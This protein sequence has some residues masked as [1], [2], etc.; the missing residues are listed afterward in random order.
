M[1][2]LCVRPNF[3]Q[4]FK[5]KSYLCNIKNNIMKKFFLLFISAFMLAPASAQD[6]ITESSDT[7]Y[8]FWPHSNPLFLQDS[9]LIGNHGSFGSMIW[10]NLATPGTLVY[11][12]S[13]RGELPLDSTIKVSLAWRDQDSQYHYYD[14]VYLDSS[15]VYRQLRFRAKLHV[16]S[17]HLFDF[18][19][20]CNEVY[21][22]RPW[23]V[24]DTFYVVIRYQEIISLPY[25]LL[26]VSTD[27]DSIW[28]QR[29]AY[30]ADDMIFPVF[31]PYPPTT[32]DPTLQG[33][34]CWGHEFPILEPNRTRCHKP[35]GLHLTDRGDTWAV[36]AWNGGAGDSYRVTVEGPDSTFVVETTDTSVLLQPLTPDASYRVEVQSLCH[37]QYYDF[38]SSFLN[39]GHA[40]MGFRTFSDG[41]TSPDANQQIDISPNPA[42]RT[43]DITSS[44]PI[45]GIELTD[46]LGHK[47][48]EFRTPHSEFK[49]TL[50]LTAYPRGTY[51]LR[52]QTPAGPTTKKLLI[53]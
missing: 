6:T 30:Q 15:V 36:L 7:C 39:P 3:F 52:I 44:L 40:H 38:D 41:V 33:F 27:R 10:Q 53:Q 8:M 45:T 5:Y 46:V 47:V 12:I 16:D 23:S 42:S 13:L 2:I 51:L 19:E 14:T 31:P 35:T 24:P 43:V 17:A 11:G 29:Y 34:H 25:G 18:E 1:R 28:Q 9:V 50:D 49:V 37:Y 21:F 4:Q 22:H 32:G 26:Y 48:S 20:K